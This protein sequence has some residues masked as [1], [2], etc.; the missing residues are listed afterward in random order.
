MLK[1]VVLCIRD[2]E[3]VTL[4]LVSF[5]RDWLYD[6]Q[7]K[8]VATGLESSSQD[9]SL[10]KSFKAM[11]AATQQLAK[12]STPHTQHKPPFQGVGTFQAP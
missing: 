3:K 9:F 4:R 2:Q 8:P 5:L 11:A 1:F 10:Q 7:A 6:G 12:F